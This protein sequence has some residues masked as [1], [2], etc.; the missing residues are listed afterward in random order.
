MTYGSRAKA[1]IRRG[2]SENSYTTGWDVSYDDP[3][4]NSFERLSALQMT[5]NWNQVLVT[6]GRDIQT[7]IKRLEAA[8]DALAAKED[9]SAHSLIRQA[10]AYAEQALS[11]PAPS[12]TTTAN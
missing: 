6:K 9:E 11:T 3:K 2:K 1:R 8:N 7:A 4:V 5:A 10:Y 12:G